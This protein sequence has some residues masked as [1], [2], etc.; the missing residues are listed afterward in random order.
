MICWHQWKWGDTY[1]SQMFRIRT[2]DDLGLPLRG[3]QGE[4]IS[5]RISFTIERQKATCAK[6]GK[7][8]VRTVSR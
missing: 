4:P 5:E 3:P 2:S 8:K 6:C 7:S 1:E